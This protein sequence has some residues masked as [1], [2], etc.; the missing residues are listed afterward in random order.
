MLIQ[1][2]VGK[3]CTSL[4]LLVYQTDTLKIEMQQTANSNNTAMSCRAISL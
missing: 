4:S 1:C 2:S 3:V